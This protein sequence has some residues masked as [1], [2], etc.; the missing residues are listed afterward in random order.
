MAKN[1]FSFL[2]G[3][4]L[5]AILASRG[6]CIPA[7]G[8]GTYS[9]YYGVVNPGDPLEPYQQFFAGST[10]VAGENHGFIISPDTPSKLT[11]WANASDKKIGTGSGVPIYLMNTF[12]PGA[13][14]N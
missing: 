13:T 14:F 11:V 8:V 4:S 7:L 12:C 10:I 1:L 9:G 3:L 2:F 6:L 5:V